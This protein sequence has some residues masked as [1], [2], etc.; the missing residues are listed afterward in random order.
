[1]SS[2]QRRMAAVDRRLTFHATNVDQPTA[3]SPSRE[4]RDEHPAAPPA[5]SAAARLAALLREDQRAATHDH[6][7]LAG[8]A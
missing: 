4:H 2:W 3:P 6:V 7:A 1:M 8:T 5:T